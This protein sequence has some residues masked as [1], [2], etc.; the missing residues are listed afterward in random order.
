M[1]QFPVGVALSEVPVNV[2]PL[3]DDTD[4]KT[5][6]E[7]VTYNQAGMDLVW[8]FVTAAGAYTQTAVTPATAGVY[9]W[10][11]QGNGM[12]SIEIPAS[13]GGSINNDAIGYGWFSGFATGILPWRGPVMSFGVDIVPVTTI[14]TLASQTSFTLTDGSAN[15]DA[16]NGWSAVIRDSAG[17]AQRALGVVSDYVGS[18]KTVTLDADPGIFTMA[19][20]DYVA[21][22]PNPAGLSTQQKADVNAQADLALTD[23]DPPTKAEL[24]VLGTA[25]L[26]TSSALATVDSNVDAIKVVTDIIGTT[27]ITGATSG[28]PSTTSTNTDLTGYADDELI[29]R[30]IIFVGGTADGQA[31]EITDYASTN[32]VVTFAALTTAPAASDT[33]VI[34]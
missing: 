17:S 32:G 3:I 16:Y 30:V 29:G 2:A 5:R 13:G 14:A 27:Q 34:L 12:Y 1:M 31:A 21:L 22:V 4:F 10:T 28:T 8:N 11:N 19:V 26:A 9:D 33:F 23:Y 25:A 18:T 20:G 15:N 7:S 6:E 24:D